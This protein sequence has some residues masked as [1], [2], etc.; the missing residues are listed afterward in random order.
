MIIFDQKT[1]QFSIFNPNAGRNI[2]NTILNSSGTIGTVAG[3][4]T[5]MA[6][7]RKEEE[8]LQHQ[9]M[10]PDE[11]REAAKKKYGGKVGAAI[12]GFVAGKLAGKATRAVSKAIFK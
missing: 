12:K 6:L 2:R 7:R 11:A 1:R 10:T 4:G 8:R 5:N 3:V 9:G